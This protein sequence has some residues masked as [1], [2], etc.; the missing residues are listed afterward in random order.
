MLLL[1]SAA[2]GATGIGF[3]VGKRERW[4]ANGMRSVAGQ[5][6]PVS[7]QTVSNS[8]HHNITGLEETWLML[9]D[10][11]LTAVLPETKAA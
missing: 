10:F 6:A 4:K 8:D 3:V 1:S 5:H 7:V 11:A 2:M 9:V